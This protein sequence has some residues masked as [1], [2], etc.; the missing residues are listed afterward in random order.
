[1][2][3]SPRVA[4]PRRGSMTASTEKREPGL[5]VCLQIGE[6][7]ID[8][9]G[10]GLASLLERGALAS[11]PGHFLA[12]PIAGRQGVREGLV[13]DDACVTHARGFN[14]LESVVRLRILAGLEKPNGL[15]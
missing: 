9:G 3:G 5:Q 14:L 12:T 10:R 8:F 11:Q 13:I 6:R 7:R 15:G 4:S 1:M 2:G